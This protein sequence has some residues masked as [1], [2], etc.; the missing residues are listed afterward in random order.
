MTMPG[1]AELIFVVDRSG[2]MQGIKEDMEGGF[3]QFIDEQRKVPGTCHVS[4]IHFDTE[5][6][7]MFPRRSL[8][9]HLP[10]KIEPRGG[11]ALLDAMGRT[12]HETGL[13]LERTPPESRPS[14]VLM[15]TI[16]DGEENS[17]RFYSRSKV[18]QMISH[19]R[20]RYAWEFMFL[21][22]NQDAIAEAGK[23]GIAN[24]A[25]TY[26]PDSASVGA[27]L[28]SSSKSAARYRSGGALYSNQEIRADYNLE[29]A[30]GPPAAPATQTIVV[31]VPTI[32]GAV[33]P[34]DGKP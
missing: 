31:N 11:T 15:I 24:S 9:D 34:D 7:E 12:I 4:V 18:F 22:A 8:W 3:K 29:L 6:A 25:L 2:S 10:F 1:S 13:R 5:Y 16:S 17:S 21:G 28:R 32:P 33:K 27:A 14:R 30:N 26:T 20:E 23:M 19:Q